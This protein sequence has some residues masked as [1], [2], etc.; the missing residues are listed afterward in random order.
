M[1]S[2][3]Q[4]VKWMQEGKLVHRAS[5]GKSKVRLHVCYPGEKVRDDLHRA[6]DFTTIELLAE[7]WEIA[8]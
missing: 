8:E 7:D 2:I 5:W 6:A 1:A 3:Q 4:A